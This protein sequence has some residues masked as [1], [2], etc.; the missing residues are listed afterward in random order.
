[1]QRM[2]SSLCL[3]T[4]CR[5][6]FGAQPSAPALQIDIEGSEWQV[7]D[8]FF[9][10]NATIPFS[11][12]LIELHVP[13]I[14]RHWGSDAR[15]RLSRASRILSVHYAISLLGRVPPWHAKSAAFMHSVAGR[16][17][18][19]AQPTVFDA[20]ECCGYC[21]GCHLYALHG[22]SLRSSSSVKGGHPL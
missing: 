16:V 4:S 1:M 19:H 12:I 13:T 6:K 17:S 5:L 21:V 7:L 8:E 18:P 9:R 10:A 2:F 3:N 15:H 22:S 14:P 20:V 11:Q